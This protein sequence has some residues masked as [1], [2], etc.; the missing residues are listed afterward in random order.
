MPPDEEF[1][2]MGAKRG[3]VCRNSGFTDRFTTPC[4]YADFEGER[5]TCPDCGAPIECEVE[6]EP[7]S[8]CRIRE[9]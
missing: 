6:H 8:V 4:C 1:G 5:E 3:E 7:V 9:E 2:K